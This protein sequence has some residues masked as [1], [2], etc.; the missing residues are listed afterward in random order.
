MSLRKKIEEAREHYPGEV[1]L[2]RRN[3][4]YIDG[5]PKEEFAEQSLRFAYFL[6]RD[7]FIVTYAWGE[8]PELMRKKRG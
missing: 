2:I 6:P 4:L 8:P 3:A 5:I 7:E 1:F